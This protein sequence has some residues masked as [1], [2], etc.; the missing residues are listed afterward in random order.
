MKTWLRLQ[1][2]G[3]LTIIAAAQTDL[4]MATVDGVVRNLKT[5]EP[6]AD[7]RVSITPELQLPVTTPAAAAA[8]TAT[9]DADG[10]F[11]ITA[12]TPGRYAVS[13]TRTL[14]FRPRRDAGPAALSLGEGQRLTGIQIL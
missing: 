2:L 13:A 3:V 6:L 11:S 9:T 12:V 8:K 14:F 4:R 1:L 5:G 7:V 10:R